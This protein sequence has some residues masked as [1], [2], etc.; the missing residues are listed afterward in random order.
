[1]CRPASMIVTKQKVFW[2]EKTESHHEIITEFNLRETDARKQINLVP[3]EIIPPNNDFSAP[4]SKWEFHIDFAGFNRELPD[5]FDEN[6]AEKECRAALKY[7][8]KQKVVSRKGVK[9]QG[10]NFFVIKGAEVKAL[11]NS[12]VK[13]L[14]NSTVEALDNSTVEALDNSTVKAW[15]NSTVKALGNSTVKA[16]DNSTVKALGNSTVEALGNSTVEALDNSTVKAWDNSTVKAWDNSTVKAWDNST[17]ISYKT[18]DPKNLKSQNAVL[19]DRSKS[20]VKCVI[21]KR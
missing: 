5:W 9:L 20:K 19:V 6:K 11:G 14:G 13:A 8:K 17:I 21:G 12:T 1:M 18:F 7:W 15:D 10:G 4:V 3:I 2:S 16:W